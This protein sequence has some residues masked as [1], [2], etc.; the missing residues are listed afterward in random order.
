M[1]SSNFYNRGRDQNLRMDLAYIL[2]AIQLIPIRFHAQVGGAIRFNQ[3]GPLSSITKSLV[4]G[5]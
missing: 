2:H 4:E 3:T 1:D 5:L